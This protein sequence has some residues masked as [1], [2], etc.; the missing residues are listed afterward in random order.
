VASV[1]DKVPAVVVNDTGAE[2]STFPLMSNTMAVIVV[3]PPPLG[4][5]VGFAFTETLPTAAVPMAILAA[6]VVPVVAPPDE[7]TMVAVPLLTP[8]LNLTITRPLTSVRAS[9]GSIEPSVVVK[10]M[11]VPLCGG[12][13]LASSTCAVRSAV[14]FVGSAVAEAV[15]MIVEPVGARRGT[16][17][18]APVRSRIASPNARERSRQFRR[19][20]MKPLTILV[21]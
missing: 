1:V 2:L 16:F 21:P 6:P 10:V 17:W 12:L 9:D 11:R 8:A 18:Q 5:L 13:A 15:R 7:A 14:A 4:T 3:E 20:I 19:D